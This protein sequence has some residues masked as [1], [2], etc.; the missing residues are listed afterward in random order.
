M[1]R[2]VDFS[3][4][5]P[6]EALCFGCGQ[7][8]PL[9][10]RAR[11]RGRFRCPHCLNDNRVDHTGLGRPLRRDALAVDL[12][13][14]AICPQCGAVNRVPGPLLT[15]RRY[16]CFNCRRVVAV[17][18]ELRV[19]RRNAMP[20][21]AVL[22]VVITITVARLARSVYDFS[23]AVRERISTE[24]VQLMDAAIDLE[25]PTGIVGPGGAV[26]DIAGKATNLLT[27][28]T[29]LYIRVEL[30][31]GRTPVL[32]DSVVLPFVKPREQR[33]FR[34]RMTD[35]AGRRVDQVDARLL[36]VS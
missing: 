27:S 6:P 25:Q 28:P 32:R 21:V 36:G 34:I 20:L 3:K 31:Q 13:P 4:L 11:G 30:Y 16:T 9:S 26:Y 23:R 14:E 15:G 12:L 19:V 22:L 10:L 24:T 8:V 2:S 18:P 17:P 35:P 1:P 7:S 29:T 33:S 5:P